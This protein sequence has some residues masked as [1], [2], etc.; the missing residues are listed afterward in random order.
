MH[1]EAAASMLTRIA[2]ARNETDRLFA[3]I[4]PAF[5]YERPIAERHRL[6][7]YIG[8]LE[9]FDWNLLA[10]EV[11]GLEPFDPA[12][13]SLFA[14]G[15]DPVDGGLP[16]DTPADWPSLDEVFAY[17]DAVRQ[18]LDARI[19]QVDFSSADADLA[20]RCEVAI[21]HR[22]M[23]AETLSYLMHQLPLHFKQRPDGEPAVAAS[24]AAAPAA[25]QRP[26]LQAAAVEVPAGIAQLGIARDRGFGWD[27]ELCDDTPHAVEVPAFTM[28]R[29]MVSNGD[30]AE[31]VA[32]GGYQQPTFWTPADWTWIQTADIRHPAFWQAKAAGEPGGGWQIK[33]MF[34]LIDLP[35]DWPVYVSHA[36]A[37]A[38]ARYVG[39]ALPSEAQ[40]QHAASADLA[41]TPQATPNADFLRWNP[42]PVD[43]AEQ[44]M[45]EFG[46]VGMFGNGWEWTS[47]HFA[48]LPGFRPFAF[49]PGY[50]AN[51]FDA[52]HFVMKGGSPRTAACMLRPSF[53]NWFQPHY[54]YIYAGFRCVGDTAAGAPGVA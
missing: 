47:T 28:D 25:R 8:H 20:T 36:E 2:A 53:R 12:A 7:F 51:F 52:Q 18:R 10:T 17:R 54:P 24:A 3:L 45:N 41:P 49:Y 13:D 27:N 35:L 40:W 4:K 9:A 19:A 29:H 33:T 15:I 23:H 22:L 6:V 48:P 26:V 43:A 11:F 5:L 31:F 16:T 39:R 46:L 14:F 37:S 42:L 21:E 30:F 1:R 50:S 32:A 38:Y 34:D 44:G